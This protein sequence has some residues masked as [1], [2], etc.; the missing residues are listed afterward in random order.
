MPIPQRLAVPPVS[1]KLRAEML[2]LCT[3]IERALDAGDEAQELLARWHAH[4]RR[5]FEPREFQTYWKAID[6]ETFVD[7]ALSPTP[8]L[9]G[10]ATYAEALAV[11]QAVEEAELSEAE[12]SYF[13]EWLEAQFP[14]SNISDLIYWPDEWFGNAALFREENGAFKPEAELSSDQVLSYAIARSGRTLP[15][16]PQDIPLP[17]PLFDFPSSH[18]TASQNRMLTSNYGGVES[19][20]WIFKSSFI[21]IADRG[22]AHAPHR[23]SSP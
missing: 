4:A 20:N 23:R 13:I 17:F 12:T 9:D 10:Q 8:A 1:K 11:L 19:S 7:D 18:A 21:H 3:A 22:A 2:S 6:I 16:A 14:G 5:R 15:G